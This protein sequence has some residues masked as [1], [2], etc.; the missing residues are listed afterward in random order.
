MESLRNKD[1]DPVSVKLLE[2]GRK[3]ELIYGSS[4]Q[5]IGG[6]KNLSSSDFRAT[7]SYSQSQIRGEKE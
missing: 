7:Y 6:S 3:S 2:D 1:L 4:R 5:V